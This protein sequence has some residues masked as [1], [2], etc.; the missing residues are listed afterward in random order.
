MTQFIRDFGCRSR[1]IGQ[2][3]NLHMPKIEKPLKKI[4]RQKQFFRFILQKWL[5]ARLASGGEVRFRD[6]L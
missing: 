1:K 2:E 6:F 3:N 4:V 5:A